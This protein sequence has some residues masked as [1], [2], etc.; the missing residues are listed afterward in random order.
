MDELHITF[1]N[2]ITIILKEYACVTPSSL[3]MIFESKIPPSIKRA[4]WLIDSQGHAPPVILNCIKG[5]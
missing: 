3:K 1:T 4:E 5:G 2:N